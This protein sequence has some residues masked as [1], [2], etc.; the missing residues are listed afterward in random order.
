MKSIFENI[1]NSIFGVDFFSPTKF[2]NKDSS[3]NYQIKIQFQEDDKEPYYEHAL[4]SGI[5]NA[6]RTTIFNRIKQS[7]NFD[8]IDLRKNN[9]DI[10]N[11]IYN[12]GYHDKMLVHYKILKDLYKNTYYEPYHNGVVGG[13]ISLSGN[14]SGVEI[15]TDSNPEF[16]N[17]IITTNKPLNM[18]IGIK[19]DSDPRYNTILIDMNID[20]NSDFK[21]WYLIES[22]EDENWDK[23]IQ[24]SRD[25]KI[26][27][28]ID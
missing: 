12:I 6:I 1:N 18:D 10:N 5:M 9:F 2:E 21:I 8:F 16:E 28:L 13:T 15:W 17:I 24:W 25:N 20:K 26:K 4:E 22:E 27:T 11:F 7:D 23:F 3:D 19:F 14:L